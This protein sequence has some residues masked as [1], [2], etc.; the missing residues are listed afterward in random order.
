[1][2]REGQTIVRMA[3]WDG[4]LVKEHGIM[5]LEANEVS[6]ASNMDIGERGQMIRRPGLTKASTSDPAGMKEGEH[7]FAFDTLADTHHLVLVDIDGEVYDT[8][9]SASPTYALVESN[10][11]STPVTIAAQDDVTAATFTDSSDVTFFYLSSGDSGDVYKWDGASS[12]S[13][14]QITDNTLDGS[15]TEFPRSQGLARFADR[16]WAINS[17]GSASAKMVFSNAGDADQWETNDFI[18]VQP[19]AGANTALKVF[20]NTLIIF[21][22]HSTVQLT[23]TSTDTF[24]LATLSDRFGCFNRKSI[25]DFGD[26]LIWYDHREGVISFDGSTAEPVNT[27]L[28]Q[29]IFDNAPTILTA[30]LRSGVAAVGHKRKYYLS[31][32]LV[33]ITYVYDL[34]TGAWTTHDYGPMAYAD[35]I[36]QIP[37]I[38][39][40]QAVTNTKGVWNMFNTDATTPLDDVGTL[41]TST[42][43]TAWFSPEPDGTFIDTHRLLKMI[44]QFTPASGPTPVNVT[45]ELYTNFDN[46]TVVESKV[47]VVDE[48]NSDQ[49]DP[50]V[51]EFENHSARA[52]KIRMTHA[53]AAENWQLNAIDFLFYTKPTVSGVR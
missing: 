17:L 29:E 44:P 52:F 41:I 25:V 50:L 10:V 30:R 46:N 23:G 28:R 38:A 31:F 5:A 47:V 16:M 24:T 1:M 19:H 3:G 33:P 11:T 9:V 36:S 35:L 26:Q 12:T 32:N 43:A 8:A 37:L 14:T 4:G 53:T 42:F 21:K 13:W 39:G 51:I 49:V 34:L 48:A 18:L 22:A 7:L 15:G 6:E 2:V 27:N 40:A 20:Q 45:I